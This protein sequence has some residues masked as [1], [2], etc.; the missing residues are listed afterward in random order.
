VTN[1]SALPQVRRATLTR[2]SILRSGREQG[3]MVSGAGTAPH[4]NSTY[5]LGAIGPNFFRTLQI[6]FLFGRDFTFRDGPS[7]PRVA[8]VNEALA[9]KY[10]PGTSPVGATIHLPGEPGERT[11]IGIVGN[12]KFGLRDYAPATPSTYRSHK[13]P[14]ICA[15]RC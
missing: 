13:P 9:I 7:T 10:F 3:L 14:A 12:I 6:P 1:L 11:I 8:I 5:V 15:G 4:P 2:Y